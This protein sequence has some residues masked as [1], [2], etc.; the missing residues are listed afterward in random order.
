MAATSLLGLRLWNVV[1]GHEEFAWDRLVDSPA[2]FSADSKHFAWTG[3]D[4]RSAPHPWVVRIGEDK[5][6]RLGLPIN[7]LVSQ[8]VFSPDGATLA[9]TTDART[10]ELRD[11]AT[12][13][14]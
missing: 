14:D 2:F 12:G 8:L 11:V 9:V 10:L 6:R 5:P 1:N 13:K 3:Y 4:E 7:N